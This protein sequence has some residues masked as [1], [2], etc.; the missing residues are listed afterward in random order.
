MSIIINLLERLRTSKVHDFRFRYELKD[1]CRCCLRNFLL[2]KNRYLCTSV[3]LSNCR[4]IL[5]VRSTSSF[6]I[7][8]AEVS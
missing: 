1:N 4:N 7:C 3:S 2:N 5:Q 8:I 6:A